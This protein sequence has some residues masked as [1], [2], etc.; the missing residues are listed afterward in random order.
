MCFLGTVRNE[1]DSISRMI[2]TTTLNADAFYVLQKLL[3]CKKNLSGYS[4]QFLIVHIHIWQFGN[5]LKYF[6]NEKRTKVKKF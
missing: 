5:I 1:S 6:D 3:H 4:V 2:K